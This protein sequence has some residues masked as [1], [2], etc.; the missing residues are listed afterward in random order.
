[1][2]VLEK[3]ENHF[4]K[5]IVELDA[6]SVVEIIKKQTAAETIQESVDLKNYIEAVEA[7]PEHRFRYMSETKSH[8]GDF[9]KGE[10]WMKNLPRKFH[11]GISLVS[12][13]ESPM[14]GAAFCDRIHPALLLSKELKSRPP[15]YKVDLEIDRET[16]KVYMLTEEEDHPKQYI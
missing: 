4:G 15:V 14:T 5:D 9:L 8:W 12:E 13:E 6:K 3:I 16:K 1:M 11:L 10:I 2:E 7:V